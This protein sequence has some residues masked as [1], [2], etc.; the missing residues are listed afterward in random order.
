M[1]PI[2]VITVAFTGAIVALTLSL[3]AYGYLTEWRRRRW[4]GYAS[5]RFSHGSRSLRFDW[6]G[7]AENSRTL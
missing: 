1:D 6:S 5:R 3:S 7:T 4:C 2:E